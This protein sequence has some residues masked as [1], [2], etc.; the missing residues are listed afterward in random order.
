[1]MKTTKQS[2]IR[3]SAQTTATIL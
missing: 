2:N 3:E 1:M